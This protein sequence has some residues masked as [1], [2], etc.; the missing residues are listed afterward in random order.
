MFEPSTLMEAIRYFDDPK[1]V[2]SSWCSCG[3]RMES[4]V[5]TATVRKSTPS[6]PGRYGVASPP[7]VAVSFRCE[8]ELSWKE[9]RSPS[10]RERYT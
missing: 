10:T 9:V 5:R 8:P 3:G 1:T 7:I 6:Q 2:S 4:S